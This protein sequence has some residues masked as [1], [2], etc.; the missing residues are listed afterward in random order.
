M[1]PSGLLL[2]NADAAHACGRFAGIKPMLELLIKTP[3]DFAASPLCTLFATTRT[4]FWRVPG[5]SKIFREMIERSLKA[6]PTPSCFSCSISFEATLPI[7]PSPPPAQTISRAVCR[8]SQSKF[9]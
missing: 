1:Q 8:F 6:V 7:V 3:V 5:I 9:H 2:P 4:K